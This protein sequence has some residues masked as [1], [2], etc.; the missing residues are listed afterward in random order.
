[1]SCDVSTWVSSKS[2][3]T[4][5]FC[6]EDTKITLTVVILIS[7]YR[8]LK[9]LWT[10]G[11]PSRDFEIIDWKT[12]HYCYLKTSKPQDIGKPYSNETSLSPGNILQHDFVKLSMIHYMNVEALY[13]V[14][15]TD[16]ITTKLLWDIRTLSPLICL[17]PHFMVLHNLST[18]KNTKKVQ[19]KAA[20]LED[21][22]S[23][24]NIFLM[25][26]INL[27]ECIYL[28]YKIVLS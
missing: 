20:R 28:I 14:Q 24:R 16:H 13:K 11:T 2:T 10:E 5:K 15:P 26:G 19:S 8:K 3:V 25:W 7:L 9:R 4:S 17:H 18:L 1:M 21:P 6:H 23:L 22:T 12:E 27:W